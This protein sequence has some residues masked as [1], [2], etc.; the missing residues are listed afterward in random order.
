MLSVIIYFPYD[1]QS[2][3]TKEY[4]KSEWSPEDV[5]LQKASEHHKGSQHNTYTTSSYDKAIIALCENRNSVV[6]I[7]TDL[8]HHSLSLYEKQQLGHS[9]KN[10]LLCITER[11]PVSK[12]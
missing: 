2:V 8:G 12:R 4:N 10:L 6:E 11:Q 1:F 9:A 7:L 5:K 3:N